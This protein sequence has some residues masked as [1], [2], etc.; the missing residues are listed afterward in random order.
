MNIVKMVSVPQWK[1]TESGWVVEKQS[2]LIFLE[3]PIEIDELFVT[4]EQFKKLFPKSENIITKISVLWETLE[5]NKKF[6]NKAA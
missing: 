1:H 3:T 6:I 5:H 4:E 2:L